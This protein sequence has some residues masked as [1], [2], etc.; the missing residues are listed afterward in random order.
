MRL[1][2]FFLYR[3][4]T[5]I[6]EP[7]RPK[8]CGSR[9]GLS[10]GSRPWGPVLDSRLGR[11]RGAPSALDCA[12]KSPGH[13]SGQ[14]LRASALRVTP[15]PEL[16]SMGR[17]LRPSARDYFTMTNE[18]PTVG[19]SDTAR[20]QLGLAHHGAGFKSRSQVPQAL[21]G[22]RGGERC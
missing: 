20:K 8:K 17:Q 10:L 13:A 19:D 4:K 11:A 15:A 7:N 14:Y 22:I 9:E 18:I 21:P 16:R 3:P 5:G 1:F 2:F 12:L 6:R